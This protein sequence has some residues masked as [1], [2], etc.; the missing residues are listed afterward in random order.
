MNN[1]TDLVLAATIDDATTLGNKIDKLLKFTVMSL[2]VTVSTIATWHK[3]KSII[4][5]GAAALGGLALWFVVINGVVF[6]DS[7]GEDLTPNGPAAPPGKNDQGA[8]TAV[9]RLAE[10]GQQ[11]PVRPGGELQ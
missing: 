9:V 4:A 1:L 2:M 10:T 3:T 6:R 11:S 8:G 5:A 7:V